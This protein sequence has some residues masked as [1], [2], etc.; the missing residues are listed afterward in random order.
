MEKEK[1][2]EELEKEYASFK[3]ELGIKAN[4]DDMDFCFNLKNFILHEG[5]INPDFK[6]MVVKRIA[7]SMSAWA[8]FYHRL[9]MPNPGNMAEV[10]ENKALDNKEIENCKNVLNRLM[11][12]S[13]RC[14]LININKDKNDI[15]SFVNDSY[16][17][18]KECLKPNTE[19]ILKKMNKMWNEQI[20]KKKEDNFEG[21]C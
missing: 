14:A 18:W 11:E 16:S 19:S 8:N 1:L 13:S 9:L 5:Y 21:Y 3:E 15:A 10:Q 12:L 7:D 20:S 6:I 4:L 17:F 2:L